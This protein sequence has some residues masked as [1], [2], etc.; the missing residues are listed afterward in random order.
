VDLND[1][2]KIFPNI[3]M[4]TDITQSSV[5]AESEELRGTDIKK[6]DFKTK[7][8]A[9]LSLGTMFLKRSK[10]RSK[11]SAFQKPNANTSPA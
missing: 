2:N 9:V 7:T 8:T 4:A 1:R 3:H 6:Y 11:S 5:E 10:T